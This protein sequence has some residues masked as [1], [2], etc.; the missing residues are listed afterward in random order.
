M[1]LIYH[2]D[3]HVSQM[4]LKSDDHDFHNYASLMT[5]TYLLIMLLNG[6]VMTLTYLLIMTLNGLVITLTY[7]N[8]HATEGLVMTLTYRYNH[9]TEQLGDDLDLPL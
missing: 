6:L 4:T 2:Y 8:N 1:T 7:L 5:L 9:A 3:H